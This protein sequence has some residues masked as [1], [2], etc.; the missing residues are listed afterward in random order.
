MVKLRH[1]VAVVD[2]DASLRRS[3]TRLLNAY[4]F[5]AVEYASAEAFLAQDPSIDI[6]CLVLDIDLNGGMSGMELQRSLKG[7][8]SEM[9]V[10]FITA[11]DDQRLQLEA[12]QA[13]CVAYLRKP[14]AGSDLIV[15]VKKALEL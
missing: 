15:A 6:R 4:G 10:I 11:L 9:P 1:T 13:G 8:R 3:V 14:F 2:D 5:D 12:E 7:A